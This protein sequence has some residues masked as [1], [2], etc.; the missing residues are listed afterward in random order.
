MSLPVAAL[1]FPSIS[2]YAKSAD[3]VYR[4]EYDD[5][6]PEETRNGDQTTQA[7]HPGWPTTRP[8]CLS[9]PRDPLGS[10]LQAVEIGATS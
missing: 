5:G 3:V 10:E 9:R 8:L 1:I 7:T 6:L 2:N 4:S